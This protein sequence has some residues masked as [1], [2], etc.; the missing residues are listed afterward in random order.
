MKQVNVDQVYET[1]YEE[2]KS[3]ST[4]TNSTETGRYSDSFTFSFDGLTRFVYKHSL[5]HAPHT[6][7]HTDTHAH[8]G[9]HTHTR[10]H[11]HTL[12]LHIRTH[13]QIQLALHLIHV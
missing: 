5:A 13:T 3:W 7:L 11:T 9:P 6:H 8:T 2:V 1:V 4:S 10:T 12:T